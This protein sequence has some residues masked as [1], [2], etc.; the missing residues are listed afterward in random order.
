MFFF[1][2]AI[3]IARSEQNCAFTDLQRILKKKKIFPKSLIFF[4]ESFT[5]LGLFSVTIN[6]IV[7]VAG[8]TLVYGKMASVDYISDLKK[9]KHRIMFEAL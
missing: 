1:W 6:K 9:S 2:K 3:R 5:V 4:P 8:W 7:T